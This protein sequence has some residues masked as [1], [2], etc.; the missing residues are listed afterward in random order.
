MKNLKV[1]SLIT[2]VMVFMFSSCKK[3]DETK[4]DVDYLTAGNWRVT[5]MEIDPA[6]DIPGIGTITDVYEY[7]VEDCDKDDLIRFNPDGT[8]VEDQGAIK[9][10]PDD[11]QTI[12]DGTW[13]LNGNIITIKYP[14]EEPEPATINTINSTTL[15]VKAPISF[16]FEM[17]RTTYTATV[18]MT[19]Q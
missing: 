12:T 1:L 6:I 5:G 11:P 13:T 9:C 18:T 8:L 17:S 14:N 15:I 2:V 16:D 4:S 19:L 7:M 10:D 3:D